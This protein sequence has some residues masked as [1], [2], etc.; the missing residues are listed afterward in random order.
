MRSESG[1]PLTAYA[2]KPVLG[3]GGEGELVALLDLGVP[4]VDG[5]GAGGYLY[6][7]VPGTAAARID[8]HSSRFE[9]L[10]PAA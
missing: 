8:T 9:T 3:G 5:G 6:A 1:Q 2:T 7:V 4:D 10:R